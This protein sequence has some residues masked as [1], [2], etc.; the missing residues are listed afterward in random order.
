MAVNSAV[1]NLLTKLVFTVTSVRKAKAPSTKTS[2][3]HV[4][5]WVDVWIVTISTPILPGKTIGLS[6]ENEKEAQRWEEG[7]T[8]K[9]QD[10]LTAFLGA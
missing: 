9:L 10:M 6:F 3:S 7:K 1:T 8:Y 4:D 5:P 2:V